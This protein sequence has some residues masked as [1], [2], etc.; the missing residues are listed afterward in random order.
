MV[1]CRSSVNVPR[2]ST[3]RIAFTF[4]FVYC[5]MKISCNCT[6]QMS[7]SIK[8]ILK[9]VLHGKALC[10]Y[11]CSTTCNSTS[12]PAP[13]TDVISEANS[14]AR[15][16]PNESSSTN[17]GAQNEQRSTTPIPSTSCDEAVP[18]A[19]MYDSRTA[20]KNR[21]QIEHQE[22]NE[23][24][25]ATL[26]N[27]KKGDYDETDLAML[28]MLKKI[29]CTLNPQAQED[30]IEELQ[31]VVSQHVHLARG[32]LPQTST[33]A[34]VGPQIQQGGIAQIQQGSMMQLLNASPS[35]EVD[36]NCLTFKDI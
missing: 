25:L 20:K 10:S 13:L 27:D 11:A 31:I 14:A 36:G 32:P 28:S 4:S 30:V 5:T 12:P 8:Y 29:K 18:N 34:G 7:M 35:N 33:A 2:N 24:L 21:R 9:L 6:N 15:D 16:G 19:S 22:F 26:S 23:Q 17:Q 3:N 1:L